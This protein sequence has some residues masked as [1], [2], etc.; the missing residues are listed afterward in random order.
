MSNKFSLEQMTEEEIKHFEQPLAFYLQHEKM[1]TLKNICKYYQMKGYS[2][3]KKSEQIDLIVSHVFKDFTAADRMFE[4]MSVENYNVLNHLLIADVFSSEENRE[5][6]AQH[7]LFVKDGYVFIPVDIKEYLRRYVVEKSQSQELSDGVKL[8]VSAVNLYGY[9]SLAHYRVLAERF[10]SSQQTEE[11]LA[12][13]LHGV[14]TIKDGF[15]LNPL[16]EAAHF[17]GVGIESK[18]QYYIPD[19]WED[20]QNYFAFEYHEE[21][22]GIEVLLQFLKPY[23]IDVNQQKD[24]RDTIIVMMKMIDNPANLT[25]ILQDMIDQSVLRAFDVNQAS[26]LMLNAYQTIRNWHLGG[27]KMTEMKQPEKR[28]INKRVEKKSKKRKKKNISRLKK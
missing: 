7:F 23:I 8:L 15:V 27:Y 28:V 26:V 21:S 14:A 18:R 5:V 1:E 17:S 25:S 9:F 10:M 4:N 6:P 22:S 20:F 13:E 11:Q 3:K 12:E 24:V 16:I 2:N 19:S